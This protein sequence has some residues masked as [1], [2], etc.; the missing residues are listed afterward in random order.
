MKLCLA[1]SVIG[2][3]A[4]FILVQFIEPKELSISDISQSHVGQEVVTQG[5]ISSY[6]IDDGN[7]F[8]SLS[9]ANNSIQVVMFQK[10]AKLE[11]ELKKGDK[12]KVTG[13]VAFYKNDLEIIASS[14]EK[15]V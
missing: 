12:I 14:V 2:V 1:M 5:R 8:I 10:D 15:L 3:I 11:A 4:L 6:A 13:K 9:E 7:I